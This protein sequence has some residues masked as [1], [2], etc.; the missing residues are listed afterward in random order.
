MS[1]LI[2]TSN[3]PAAD[4]FEY[5]RSA[6]TDTFVPLRTETSR[7]E[8]FDGRMRGTELGALT[9]TEIAASPHVVR[10]TGPLIA[11]SDPGHYKIGVQLGGYCLLTQDGREAALVPGDFAIYDT[12]RPYTLAFDDSYRQLVL[13]LPR[14]LLHLP[15]EAV[16]F[17]NMPSIPDAAAPTFWLHLPSW[18]PPLRDRPHEPGTLSRQRGRVAQG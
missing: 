16:V 17:I 12:T 13:M 18:T 4:R 8:R 14:R 1:A 6:V 15:Q 2:A 11:R 9:V 10:R 5:W 3:L 7:P